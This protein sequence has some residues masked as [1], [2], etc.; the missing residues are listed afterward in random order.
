[1]SIIWLIIFTVYFVATV[2]IPPGDAILGTLGKLRD[3]GAVSIARIAN[4][5]LQDLDFFR[6]GERYDDVAAPAAIPWK[7]RV[8]VLER[9]S[10]V[11][12]DDRGVESPVVIRED[13]GSYTMWYKGKTAADNRWG[14]LRATSPDGLNWTKTGV[15]MTP[16]ETY[17]GDK[18]DPMTVICAGGIYRMWYGTDGGAGYAVSPDGISWARY[19]GNPVLGPTSGEWDNWGAG[20]QHTVFKVGDSYKMYYKGWGGKERGWTFYGLAESGDGINWIKQGKWISPQPE[21]GEATGYRNISSLELDGIYCLL[22]TT[23]PDLCLFLLASQDGRSWH[24]CGIIFRQNPDDTASDCKWTTSPSLLV[25]DGLVKMWYEGADSGG[26][27]R[28]HYAEVA[29]ELFRQRCYDTVA[30]LPE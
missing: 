12:A 18:I 21:I 1:M 11:E 23:T 8:V 5:S 26:R 28:L 19:H 13:D 17:E 14:I 30:R 15:V 6:Y 7:R 29:E 10:P 27:V 24:K 4:Q 20:G 22:H 3:A 2:I 25:E 16:T 9:G